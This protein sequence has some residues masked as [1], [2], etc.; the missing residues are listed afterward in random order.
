MLLLLRLQK[1]LLHSWN[2]KESQ[3]GNHCL[4]KAVSAYGIYPS[5][6]PLLCFLL[7]AFIFSQQ[8]SLLTQSPLKMMFVSASVPH[9]G[10]K[11]Q[12]GSIKTDLI[13]ALEG[14]RWVLRNVL[15]LDSHRKG[16]AKTKV[17]GWRGLM[18]SPPWASSFRVRITGKV[19]STHGFLLPLSFRKMKS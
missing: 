9:R 8:F 11:W 6:E 7:Q 12:A 4:L 10:I 15:M 3:Q 16:A 18:W 14:Q 17:K 1:Q 2:V 19:D 5:T 13:V